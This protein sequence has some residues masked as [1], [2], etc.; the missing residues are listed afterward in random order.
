M[1]EIEL[2]MF[3]P[4]P[5]NKFYISFESLLMVM[6]NPN[7]RFSLFKEPKL[8]TTIPSKLIKRL[9]RS[10]SGDV[11]SDVF[12]FYEPEPQDVFYICIIGDEINPRYP[13]FGDHKTQLLKEARRR[14]SVMTEEIKE[15]DEII[16]KKNREI[17]ELN[18][19]PGAPEYH[20][21][22]QHFENLQHI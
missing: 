2:Y 11:P 17:D 4:H 19:L 20:R 16:E 12:L 18:L 10:L 13:V 9:S 6:D 1:G 3:S 7:T 5:Y 8:K 22:K 21:I 15:K 14:I